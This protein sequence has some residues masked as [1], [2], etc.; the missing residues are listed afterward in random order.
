MIKCLSIILTCVFLSTACSL[1]DKSGKS[2]SRDVEGLLK[3]NQYAKASRLINRVQ[4]NH[5]DYR[6]LQIVKKQ[7]AAK[8]KKYERASLNKS[9]AFIKKGDWEA[10]LSLLETARKNVGESRVLDKGYENAGK[11]QQRLTDVL[12]RD[13]SFEHAKVLLE[14][15]RIMKDVVRINPGSFSFNL[16]FKRLKKEAGKQAKQLH[17]LA[18]AALKNNELAAAK[19]ALDYALKLRPNTKSYLRLKKRIL[20][21]MKH[22]TASAGRVRKLQDRYAVALKNRSFATARSTL[23]SILKINPGHKKAQKE[24]KKIDVLIEAEVKQ[25]MNRAA[26]AYSHGK[27]EKAV[28]IWQEAERLDPDNQEIKDHLERGYR[29]LKSLKSIRKKQTQ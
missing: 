17:V 29:V 18:K 10:G 22:G 15:L 7:I 25:L 4:R 11:K 6:M 19:Q 5:P 2:I 14:E 26:T 20:Y 9:Q 8:K 27:F 21:K 3:N 24:L 1:A 28:T 23:L 16:K 13:L 12:L